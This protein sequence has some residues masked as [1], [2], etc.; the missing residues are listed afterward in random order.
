MT[1]AVD[2]TVSRE[3][4]D[5]AEDAEWLA[6]RAALAALGAAYDDEEGPAELSVVLADDELVHRGGGAGGPGGHAGYAGR[7]HPRL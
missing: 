1:T 2:I 4:G 6:E 7:R 5:W 3:A